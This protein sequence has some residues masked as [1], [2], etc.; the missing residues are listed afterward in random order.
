M[1]IA[2]PFPYHE[3]SLTYASRLLDLGFSASLTRILTHL[4]K[5][6]RTGLFSATMTDGLSE[7]VRVGLRNPVRIVVKVESKKLLGSKRK[8]EDVEEVSERRMPAR[9]VYLSKI[10]NKILLCGAVFVFV[11]T[12]AFSQLTEFLHRLSSF[13]KD[14]PARSS[15][16][17]RAQGGFCTVYRLLCDLRVCRLLHPSKPLTRLSSISMY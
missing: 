7:L 17:F 9:C 12:R 8:A 11:L 1:I 15:V 13:G 2:F 4:P 16:E 5:Q 10:Y 6:R 14:A 3:S